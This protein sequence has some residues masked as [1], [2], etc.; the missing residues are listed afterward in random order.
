MITVVTKLPLMKAYEEVKTLED[1]LEMHFLL[2]EQLNALIEDFYTSI[3]L[4]KGTLMT[5]EQLKEY[6]MYLRD[7]C[8]NVQD[9]YLL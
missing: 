4:K 9:K 8:K 3:G 7:L 6:K 1:Y 5:L 2:P